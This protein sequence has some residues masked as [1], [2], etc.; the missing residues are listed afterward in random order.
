MVLRHI[1]RV[2]VEKTGFN[3]SAHH[4][5][6]AQLDQFHTDF[7]EKLEVWVFFSRPSFRHRRFDVVFLEFCS[8]PFA[9]DY[10]FWV[11]N[12]VI[13]WG[14]ILCLV[15]TLLFF[16]LFGVIWRV[17]VVLGSIVRSFRF[18]SCSVAFW[19]SGLR[20]SWAAWCFVF[21]CFRKVSSQSSGRVVWCRSASVMWRVLFC[22]V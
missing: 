12:W 17:R 8:F 19:S 20:S 16:A 22:G 10:Q 14:A 5:L 13:S 15:K 2:E 3:G 18:L 7:I 6:K 1:Q 21:R 9:G 11:C 4:L